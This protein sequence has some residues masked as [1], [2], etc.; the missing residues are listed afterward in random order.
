[1]RNGE[2]WSQMR[3]K[4]AM[5]RRWTMRKRRKRREKRRDSRD[6]VRTGDRGSWME[7]RRKN[8]RGRTT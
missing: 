7:R 1:M 6:R 3:I 5:S 2:K 4:R 8:G